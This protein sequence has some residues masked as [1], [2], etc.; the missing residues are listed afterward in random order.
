MAPQALLVLAGL[1]LCPSMATQAP[2][3]SRDAEI[4][5]PMASATDQSAF[6][7]LRAYADDGWYSEGMNERGVEDDEEDE[8][9]LDDR[10]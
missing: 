3:E 1:L 2:L 8:E 9:D 10:E 7:Q 6:I 5:V 4:D